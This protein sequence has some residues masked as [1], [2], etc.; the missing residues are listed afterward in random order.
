MEFTLLVCCWLEFS[1]F[2]KEGSGG[3]YTS[4]LGHHD[5]DTGLHV[6]HREINHSLSFRIDH[7]RCHYHVCFPIHQIGYQTVPFPVLRTELMSFTL[8]FTPEKS[9]HQKRIST[10]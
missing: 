10:D 9:Y 5:G 7:Q 1:V 4:P 8:H 3:Y 2:T 6:R